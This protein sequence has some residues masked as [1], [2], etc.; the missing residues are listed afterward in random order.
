VRRYIIPDAWRL[1]L[2]V[3]SALK[4]SWEK[5]RNKPQKNGKKM[6]K[7]KEIVLSSVKL[8]CLAAQE[9]GSF[10]QL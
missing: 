8:C 2:F 4:D 7:K 6:L 3:T 5:K 10:W 1:N 9:H